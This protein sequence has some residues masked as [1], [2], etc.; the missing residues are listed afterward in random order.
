MH[1]RL[2]WSVPCMVPRARN[3]RVESSFTNACHSASFNANLKPDRMVYE[4]KSGA[5][6]DCSHQRS[7]SDSPA[8]D[9]PESK[10]S[11]V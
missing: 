2:T 7:P 6:R 4:R 3:E 9:I 5:A 11:K 8:R 1:K 10:A